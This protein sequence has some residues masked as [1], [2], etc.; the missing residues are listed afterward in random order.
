MSSLSR[1]HMRIFVLATL[2]ISLGTTARVDAMPAHPQDAARILLV[3]QNTPQYPC[4]RASWGQSVANAFGPRCPITPRLRQWLRAHPGGGSGGAGP[5]SPQNVLGGYDPI[6]RCQNSTPTVTYRLDHLARGMARVTAIIK[7]YPG[8]QRITFTVLH[9]SAGWAVDDTYCA[10]R[11][12]TSIYKLNRD[13]R[14]G[15]LRCP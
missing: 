12:W 5:R 6:C 3:V 7:F 10:G 2:C 11:P 13:S 15:M 8:P 9:T 4:V 1:L 14:L